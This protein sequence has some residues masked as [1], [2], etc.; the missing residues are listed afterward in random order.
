MDLAGA[1]RKTET[2]GC[3]DQSVMQIAYGVDRNFIRPMGISMT[4]ILEHNPQAQFHVFLDDISSEDKKRIQET[5]DHYHTSCTLYYVDSSIFKTFPVRS[6]WSVAVY[7]RFFTAETLYGK[8]DRLLYVDADVL[9]VGKIDKLFSMDMKGNTIAAVPDP[10]F[11][12]ENAKHKHM[13]GIGCQG[14]DYFNAGIIL[15][16]LNKWHTEQISD[17]AIQLLSEN[18]N[19]WIVAQDQDVLNVLMANKTYWLPV[20]YNYRA[21][22]EDIY[23]DVALV[24]YSGSP[25]PWAEFY[26]S[27]AVISPFE[28]VRKISQWK[29]VPLQKAKTAQEKRFMSKK[30]L[31]QKD[32][33]HFVLWQLRYLIKKLV[34]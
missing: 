1:I 3:A 8:S 34:R 29:D 33:G 22:L 18:P 27:R 21:T 7:F 30:C 15:I 2:L 25:K 4:S 32:F 31:R 17:K 23:P 12:D 20:K 10:S 26:F 5:V 28:S 6:T 9:C 19:R 16:D 24:H 14:T 13:R 11:Q